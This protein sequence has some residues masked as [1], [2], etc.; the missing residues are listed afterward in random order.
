MVRYR[1]WLAQLPQDLAETIAFRNAERL[2]K[3]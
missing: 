2:F 1:N 3:R